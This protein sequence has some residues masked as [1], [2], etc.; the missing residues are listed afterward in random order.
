MDNV[1]FG[2]LCQDPILRQ[3]RRGGRPMARFTVAVNVWR[4]DERG[5]VERPPVFHRVICFGQLAENVS[6]SLRKGMEVLAV[7]EWVDDSYSDEQGQRRVHVAMEAR[8]I[9][10]TLR[11][12][13]AQVHKTERRTD[14]D[15]T[16]VDLDAEQSTAPGST[17]AASTDRPTAGTA[18]KLAAATGRAGPVSRIAASFGRAVNGPGSATTD[19]L[20]R[21]T[22]GRAPTRAFSGL[23]PNLTGSDDRG[24]GRP[25][26]LVAPSGRDPDRSGEQVAEPTGRGGDRSAE[27]VVSGDRVPAGAR[28]AKS[29]GRGLRGPGPDAVAADG[30]PPDRPGSKPATSSTP[31]NTGPTPEII[32]PANTSGEDVIADLRA[33]GVLG[34][35]SSAR[36]RRGTHRRKEAES[37]ATAAQAG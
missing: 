30:R 3:P 37:E 7:G 13:T 1:V 4:R 34:P 32:M 14:T 29:T 25:A 18:P 31:R 19:S 36:G 6:N 26:E 12:A 24:N 17:I 23:A 20:D 27:P 33:A 8:A 5:F 11:R 22:A 16:A 28:A 2:N 9:G 21:G 10:P 35:A 15:L